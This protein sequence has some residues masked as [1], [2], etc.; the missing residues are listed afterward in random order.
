MKKLLFVLSITTFGVSFE[1]SSQKKIIGSGNVITEFRKVKDFTSLDIDGIFDVELTQADSNSIRIEADDNLMIHFKVENV[2]N[3]LK[4]FDDDEDK[5]K[6]YTKFRVYIGVKKIN[7]L[8]LNMFGNV[9]GTN[10]IKAD[11]LDF[12]NIS[13]GETTLK[14][15]C[16]VLKADFNSAGNINLSGNAI[17]SEIKMKGVGNLN[18][19]PFK[20]ETAKITT[21]APG[22]IEINIEK[23]VSVYSDGTGFVHIKGNGSILKKEVNGLGAVKKLK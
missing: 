20:S 11:T 16:N 23:E 2:D 19:Y 12:V 3:T 4:V 1:A 8:T 15:D 10:P 7:K 5:I 13:E 18:A 14:I 17:R 21:S 9:I 22:G 6:K